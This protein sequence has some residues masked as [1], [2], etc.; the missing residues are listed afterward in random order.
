MDNIKVFRR[1]FLGLTFLLSMSF[2]LRGQSIN[3]ES[4]ESCTHEESQA[5]G[6]TIFNQ[7]LKRNKSAQTIERSFAG[8]YLTEEFVGMVFTSAE[9]SQLSSKAMRYN[10]E[11]NT[12]EI[13]SNGKVDYISGE[14]ISQFE[15]IDQKEQRRLFVNIKEFASVDYLTKGFFE[16][17]EIGR[18]G[19]LAHSRVVAKKVYSDDGEGL[20]SSISTGVQTD[21]FFAKNTELIP[22][23]SFG[24]RSLGVF[25]M[26]SDQLR[27]FIKK[28]KLK[29]KQEEDLVALAR[30]YAE[31][32]E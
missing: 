7:N 21:Y 1:G 16:V 5:P 18:I 15:F 22:V 8:P 32:I 17:L 28:K 6:L 26:Y 4:L 12:F 23:T 13:L 20:Q 30:Y 14:A 24:K 31:I 29:F 25:E 2:F 10:A 3:E 9:G 27:G 11:S 19:V